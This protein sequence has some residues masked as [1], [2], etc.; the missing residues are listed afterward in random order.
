MKNRSHFLFLIIGIAI[1]V[2]ATFLI[3]KNVQQPTD[4]NSL[5]QES[6]NQADIDKAKEAVIIFLSSLHDKQYEEASYYYGSDYT[7]LQD[8]NPTINKTDYAQLWKNGCEINGLNCLEIRSLEA[9][10][11][12]D[13]YIV[14]VW[15]SNEDGSEFRINTPDG[16]SPEETSQNVFPFTVT[17]SEDGSFKVQTMPPY[18]Q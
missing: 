16:S 11:K 1:A 14:Y 2:A 6:L 3:T 10:Q 5:V 15:F 8:W 12:D 9:G 18:T 13:A 17:K 4:I 7:Q